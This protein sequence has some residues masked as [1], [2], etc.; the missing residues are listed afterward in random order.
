[1]SH[2]FLSRDVEDGNGRPAP[3]AA[4]AAGGGAGISVGLRGK[5]GEVVQVMFAVDSK[6][7]AKPTTIGSDGTAVA[8]S[9]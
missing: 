2:L 4:A 9:G 5:P 3:T 6:C 1:M 7:V 8:H